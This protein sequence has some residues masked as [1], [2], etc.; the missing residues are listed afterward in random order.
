M[1]KSSDP[2]AALIITTNLPRAH[3]LK[4]TYSF[5]H[6]HSLN[7]KQKEKE[8]EMERRRRRVVKEEEE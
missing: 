3:R 5:S 6:P 7:K 8:K 4:W 2:Q 1:R